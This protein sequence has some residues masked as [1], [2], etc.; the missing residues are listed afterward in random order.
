LKLVDGATGEIVARFI[1]NS[2]FDSNNFRKRGILEIKRDFGGREWD[3]IVIISS[4]AL[5]EFIQR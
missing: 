3:K 5:H 2:L 4:L 1:H